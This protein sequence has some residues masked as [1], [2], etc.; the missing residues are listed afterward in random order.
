MY[1]KIRI[2][3]YVDEIALVNWTREII[4]P[5]ITMI[6]KTCMQNDGIKNLLV[7]WQFIPT[8][9]NYKTIT[10]TLEMVTNNKRDL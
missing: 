7:S 8:L 4:I 2:R 5:M 3:R 1:L 9:Q 6:A 10:A